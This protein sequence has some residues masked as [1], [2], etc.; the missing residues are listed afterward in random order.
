LVA[1]LTPFFE[2]G[3]NPPRPA[4]SQARDQ[5]AALGRTLVDQIEEGRL[6]HD[7][8]GQNIRNLFEC[9]ELGRE[10]ASISLRA[11]EDPK[12]FQRPI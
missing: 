3:E 12:S 11:G 2:L 4:A 10:G 6:G 9:L 8:L 7:R 5:A 1:L